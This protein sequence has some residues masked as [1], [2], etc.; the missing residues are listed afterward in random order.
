MGIIICQYCGLVIEY[1]E[2]GEIA[3]IVRSLS[4]MRCNR[5]HRAKKI[6]QSR[7]ACGTVFLISICY[8]SVFD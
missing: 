5:K 4:P 8:I 7:P 1:V 6:E 3:E 2:H